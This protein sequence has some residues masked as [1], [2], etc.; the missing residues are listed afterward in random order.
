M[1]LPVAKPVEM[2]LLLEGPFF[3][4]KVVWPV[5]TTICLTLATYDILKVNLYTFKISQVTG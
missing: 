4:N 1:V 2:V 3:L 5:L